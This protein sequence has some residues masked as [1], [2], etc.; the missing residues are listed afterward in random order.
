MAYNSDV[1]TVN[2]KLEFW[3]DSGMV[4]VN[5]DNYLMHLD[6]LEE[7][8][9]GDDWVFGEISSNQL[10]I[11]LYNEGSIFTPTN[12]LSP[13][14]N[15]IKSGLKIIP[16]VNVNGG[17]W[18][19]MGEFFVEEWTAGLTSS[20]V[21]IIAN[22]KMF[23]IFDSKPLELPLIR[24]ISYVNYYTRIFD[25]LGLSVMVDPS[26]TDVL[27]WAYVQ[28]SNAET[29]Q[30]LV[31]SNMAICVSDRDGNISIKRVSGKGAAV[32]T[33]S[34]S[35]QIKGID[36]EHNINSGYTGT[37][38]TYNRPQLGGEIELYS[39]DELNLP[40]GH[41]NH[42]KFE[43]SEPVIANIS[44]I[45][46]DTKSRPINI[47]YKL[48]SNNMELSTINGA[49]DMK[50]SVIVKGIPLVESL[51][52]LGQ[53]GSN[54]LSLENEYIQDRSKAQEFKQVLDNSIGLDL[55]ELSLNVRGNPSVQVGDKVKILSPMYSLSFDGIVKRANYH[56][57]GA[58]SGTL[59]VINVNMVGG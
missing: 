35:D 21:N 26:I 31:Q 1:R 53:D 27:S 14:Y 57:D 20:F 59:D 46:V 45:T 28:E 40:A 58:L 8:G 24:D 34:D 11:Q 9:T 6:I 44:S 23:K 17:S 3:F 5:K 30:K 32:A 43:F 38:V 49:T 18:R 56:F 10:S 36:A 12:K 2:M 15:D 52:N 19:K 39:L 33:F 29:I 13:Y 41:Y 48:T 7:T 47:G 22:D 37:L 51:M 54:V 4:I 55:N 16:Y 50:A 25:N 42:D